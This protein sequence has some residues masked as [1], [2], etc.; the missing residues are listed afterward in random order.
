MCLFLVGHALM[1]ILFNPIAMRSLVYPI[2]KRFCFRHQKEAASDNESSSEESSI[3]S[4]DQQPK[5]AV[6]KTEGDGLNVQS[7]TASKETDSPV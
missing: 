4:K 2:K 1:S 6:T 3:N 7:N 5:D